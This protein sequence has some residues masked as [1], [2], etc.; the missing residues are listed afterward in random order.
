M[1]L[2]VTYEIKCTVQDSN[3]D[4]EEWPS[5]VRTITTSGDNFISN[6]LNCTTSPLTV[7]LSDLTLGAD[8]L[9][10]FRN[11]S[12]TAGQNI[13]LQSGSG[14]DTLILGPGQDALMALDA[15]GMS[16]FTATAAAGTPT[17]K[18]WIIDP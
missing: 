9:A 1:A 14:D 2:T 6:V 5:K 13:T 17:L 10:L 3:G 11:Q 7:D 4:S 12:S 15:T 8:G 18:Y 16:A